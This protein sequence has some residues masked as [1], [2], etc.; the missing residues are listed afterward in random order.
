VPVGIAGA[1]A[2]GEEGTMPLLQVEPRDAAVRD[3]AA[4][5]DRGRAIEL[6]RE[7]YGAAVYRFA[8]RMLGDP[9]AAEDVEQ[10]TM[11]RALQGLDGLRPGS[12]L[13]AW[14]MTIAA[15]RALDELRRRRRLSRRVDGLSEIPD[16][17]DPHPHAAHLL[18]VQE[19]ARTLRASL[20]T[21]PPRARD[22]VVLYFGHDLTFDQVGRTLGD[23]GGT[24]QVRV[25]RALVRLQATLRRRGVE[26]AAATCGPAGSPASGARRARAR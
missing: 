1:V 7:A 22:S 18:L 16:L 5:G 12:S 26:R 23:A 11:L 15:H 17:P 21:L 13:R 3:A 10:D 2:A 20:D 24:V 19:E 25:N 8:R 6:V 4:R 9:V 14:V